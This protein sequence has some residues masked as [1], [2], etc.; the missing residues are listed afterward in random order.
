MQ[1]A[2]L[3]RIGW[4]GDIDVAFFEVAGQ[5]LFA[6]QC[7]ARFKGGVE[8]GLQGI[9]LLA[10]GGAL[11]FWP[12]ADGPQQFADGAF[13]AEILDFPLAQRLVAADV[14]QCVQRLLANGFDGL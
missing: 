1:S 6:Q 12:A 7:F 2:S 10:I 5:M 11:F 9:D 4:Q 3:A 13:S 8:F 14:F